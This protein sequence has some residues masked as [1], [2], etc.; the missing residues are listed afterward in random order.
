MH[1][2][3]SYRNGAFVSFRATTDEVEVTVLF[4]PSSNKIPGLLATLVVL[5]GLGAVFIVSFWFSPRHTDVGYQ[6]IQ[7]VPYSHKLHAG[8]M[9]MDCRYCHQM[10]EDGPHATIPDTAT[11]MN[12]HAKVRTDSPLLQQVRDSAKTGNPVPWVKV[13]MLPDYA[14]FSHSVHVRVGVGCTSCHGRIDQMEVVRQAQPLSMGWCLDCH[15]NPAP[16]IRPLDQVTNM[17]W[18]GP[19]VEPPRPLNP[20]QTCSGCHR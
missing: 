20:P 4:Q 8:I 10:V 1:T 7:P 6:P 13:H 5:A 19:A 15:R 12:C 9:G 3:R 16:H 14:Y 2:P 11:C 18:T 17:A